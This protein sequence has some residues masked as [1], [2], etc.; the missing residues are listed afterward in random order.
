MNQISTF[1]YTRVRSNE[2][3][4]FNK[5]HIHTH[6]HSHTFKY[7]YKQSHTHAINFV[8]MLTSI[9]IAS[10]LSLCCYCYGHHHRLF[11]SLIRAFHSILSSTKK[12]TYEQLQNW[13]K[14]RTFIWKWFAIYLLIAYRNSIE[15]KQ[16]TLTHDKVS[17]ENY[18]FLHETIDEEIDKSRK[19]VL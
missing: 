17:P 10:P 6:T 8:L 15:M 14:I 11:I 2:K 7:I 1:R 16:F 19:T 12:K 3:K 13:R 18:T 9:K 5:K 4:N